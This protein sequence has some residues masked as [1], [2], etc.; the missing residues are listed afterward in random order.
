MLTPRHKLKVE[1]IREEHML[2]RDTA[3]SPDASDHEMEST[4]AS[5]LNQAAHGMR[6][7]IDPNESL[8]TGIERTITAS[9]H[10][11]LR[12]TLNLAASD[13]QAM[14]LIP[15]GPIPFILAA[16][17]T[18]AKRQTDELE[19]TIKVNNGK[20]SLVLLQQPSAFRQGQ[21]PSPPEETQMICRALIETYHGRVDWLPQDN[22]SNDKQAT[23]PNI[24]LNC[25]WVVPVFD[26]EALR[27]AG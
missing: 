9:F 8:L 27:H 10:R 20:V 6:Q 16:T 12:V 18:Q 7:M 23:D 21:I 25:E 3:S 24:C 1:R 4:I 13:R 2:D 26:T 15:V 22:R 14:D 5:T 19:L 17:L 11:G